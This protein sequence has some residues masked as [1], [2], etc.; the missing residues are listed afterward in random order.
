MAVLRGKYVIGKKNGQVFSCAQIMGFVHFQKWQTLL[1]SGGILARANADRKVRKMVKKSGLFPRCHILVIPGIWN[2]LRVHLRASRQ[3]GY[4]IF[5]YSSVERARKGPCLCQTAEILSPSS[6]TCPPPGFLATSP[7]QVHLV[8]VPCPG[9]SCG[10]AARAPAGVI[11]WNDSCSLPDR[12]FPVS[13]RLPKFSKLKLFF[14]EILLSDFQNTHIF[15]RDWRLRICV[16][17][18]RTCKWRF[19]VFWLQHGLTPSN[20]VIKHS[21]QNNAPV[22]PVKCSAPRFPNPSWVELFLKRISDTFSFC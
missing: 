3:A 19:V 18:S 2:Y 14:F 7:P 6:V 22:D 15:Q 13:P 20:I 9:G 1:F 4:I 16:L 5:I 12:S 21:V 10:N 8:A 11:R 17:K